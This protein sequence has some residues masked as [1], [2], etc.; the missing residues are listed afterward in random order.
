MTYNMIY[1]AHLGRTGAN[2]VIAIHN[3][4]DAVANLAMQDKSVQIFYVS[5]HNINVP[6]YIDEPI[7]S[8][9]VLQHSHN[10]EYSANIIYIVYVEED[11]SYDIISIHPDRAIAILLAA[12]EMSQSGIFYIV[13]HWTDEL[14]NLDQADFA[15]RLTDDYLYLGKLNHDD[16]DNIYAL[17]EI[18]IDDATNVEIENILDGYVHDIVPIED[19]GNDNDIENVRQLTTDV[20]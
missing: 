5:E 13:E 11:D 1:V 2:K 7:A 19:F 12:S 6:F 18:H 8:V 20:E 14:V 9:R 4:Y 16:S 15:A 17:G 10:V 3:D